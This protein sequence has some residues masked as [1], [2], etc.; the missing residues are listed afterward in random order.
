MNPQGKYGP[1]PSSDGYNNPPG[2]YVH[3]PEKTEEDTFGGLDK[4]GLAVGGLM[5]AGGV[6]AAMHAYNV[7]IY[8][9]LNFEA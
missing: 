2:S 3:H 4:V 1:P 7:N 5:A 8:L 9:Y 6:A